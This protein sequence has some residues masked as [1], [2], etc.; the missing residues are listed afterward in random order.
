MKKIGVDLI[1]VNEMKDYRF[2][3]LPDDRMQDKWA[4]QYPFQR[5]TVSANGIIIPCTGAYNAEIMRE[6]LLNK[7]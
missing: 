7:I 6:K 2:H 1:T 3:D 5:L 4:C